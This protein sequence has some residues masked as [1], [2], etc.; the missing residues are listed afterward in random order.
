[1]VRQRLLDLDGIDVLPPADDH[2]L[3]PV[4]E[5]EEAVLIHVAAVARAEPSV[6]SQRVGGL[7]GAVRVPVLTLGPRIQTSPTAPDGSSR[8]L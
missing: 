7:L 3:D 4:G 1:M 6:R 2:V 8:P 5:E